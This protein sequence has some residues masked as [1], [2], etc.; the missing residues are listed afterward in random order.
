MGIIIADMGE[1]GPGACQGPGRTIDRV[2]LI[3]KL[4]SRLTLSRR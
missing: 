3:Q 4:N 2:Q 1:P